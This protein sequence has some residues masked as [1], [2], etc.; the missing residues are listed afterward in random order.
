MRIVPRRWQRS[1]VDWLDRCFARGDSRC[2][3]IAGAWQAYETV[4]S[5][6]VPSTSRSSATVPTDEAAARLVAK[7]RVQAHYLA[8]RCFL[9]EAAVLRAAHEL[10]GVPVAIVH[11]E[12]DL[13]CQPRNAWRV[14]RCCA[15]S[16]LAWAVGAGHSPWHP[17]THALSRSALDGFAESGD[18]SAWPRA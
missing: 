2:A 15:G 7:Y 16:R 12:R 17:A 13:V 6:D 10:R 8:R 11:G 5:G 9:G 3:E 14:H 1:V 4:L 18:F